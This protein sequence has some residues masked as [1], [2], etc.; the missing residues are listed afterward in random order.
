MNKAELYHKMMRLSENFEGKA[1]DAMEL[2]ALPKEDLGT[3]A[4]I[5]AT[6]LRGDGNGDGNC[7]SNGDCG[8]DIN[9]SDNVKMRARVRAQV[10]TCSY[11]MRF[12]KRRSQG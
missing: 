3:V 1:S 11:P 9:G 7:N 12:L 2:L 6:L 10:G 8:I 5:K 4:V